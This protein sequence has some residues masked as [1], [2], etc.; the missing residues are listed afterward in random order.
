MINH[1]KIRSTARQNAAK[2]STGRN[3]GETPN[4]VAA[5]VPCSGRWAARSESRTGS[6][7]LRRRNQLSHACAE[8]LTA[9]PPADDLPK[10]PDP[11]VVRAAETA[12]AVLERCAGSRLRWFVNS[13]G[14]RARRR[15]HAAGLGELRHGQASSELPRLRAWV[16]FWSLRHRVVAGEGQLREAGVPLTGIGRDAETRALARQVNLARMFTRTV[17]I[18]ADV[19]RGALPAQLLGTF[20]K[21]VDSL[22][23]ADEVKGLV[24]RL[25]AIEAHLLTRHGSWSSACSSGAGSPASVRSPASTSTASLTRY[26]T[27]AAR[28]ARRCA[29]PPR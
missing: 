20:E 26:S 12:V 27:A 22:R 29:C 23:T 3:P 16:R 25:L 13:E 14:R 11:G 18:L 19:P 7:L 9:P 21:L 1:R 10:S 2:S 24:A 5:L 4:G 6:K 28:R 17:H 8:L 15:V